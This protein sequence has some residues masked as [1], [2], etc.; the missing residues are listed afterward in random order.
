LI[1]KCFSQ[2]NELL[3]PEKYRI[4]EIKN[5]WLYNL[6]EN[7]NL[8][9]QIYNITAKVSSGTYIRQIAKDISKLHNIPTF[10]SDITRLD[11]IDNQ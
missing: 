9:C 5:N 1:N 6:E 7:K 8:N 3:H 11:Y 4:D 2:L 10:V